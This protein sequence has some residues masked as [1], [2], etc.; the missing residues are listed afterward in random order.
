MKKTKKLTSMVGLSLSAT[1]VFA[2]CTDK[3]AQEQPT[4]TPVKQEKVTAAG[5]FPITKE[6]TTL[7]VFTLNDPVI[8]N[9]ETNELTKEYE[10]KTNIHID[11]S[12]VSS[13]D[14]EQKRNL[15]LAANS[16]LPDVFMNTKISNV[17][18]VQYGNQGVL[19][20]LNGLIDKYGFHIKKLLDANPLIKQMIT[21]PN[22]KIYALPSVEETYHTTLGQKLWINQDWL[23]KLGLKMPETTDELYTV[24]KAFKEKDPNGNGKADEIPLTGSINGYNTNVYHFILSAFVYDRGFDE[25]P[26]ILDNGKVSTS[27]D[28]AEWKEGLKYLNK[29]YKEG[30]LDKGAITQDNAQLKQ[31]GNN[32]NDVLIGA[33]TAGAMTGFMAAGTERMKSYTSVPPLK[34]PKGVQTTGYYPYQVDSGKFAISS[35]SKNPE[36]AIR[37]I[38]WFY[39]IDGTLRSNAGRQDIEWRYGKDG[40][41]GID[42]NKGTFF[43]ILKFGNTQNVHWNKNTPAYYPQAFRSANIAEATDQESIL[44]QETKKKYEPFKP[45]EVLPPFYLEE[46]VAEEYN[47][48]DFSIMEYVKE[49]TARFV[50][51]DLDADKDWDSYLKELDKIGLK[52]YVDLTQ[53]A[54]DKQY[55]K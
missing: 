42:G 30:L 22:G 5:S 29:L 17:Q 3:A 47:G 8:E 44:Y 54:Y 11:W 14:M 40:E 38:D 55:K 46:K 25:R 31:L 19:L 33:V 36:A 45:K 24:L 51:G 52:K 7:K 32:K 23:T 48:I 27:F 12:L 18:Q 4:Q 50:V 41:K 37:W 15:L 20:E 35:A 43:R 39:S 21:T 6:K 26:F 1:L 9:I 2:G 16:D 28:N 34:G 10:E 53:K 13:K 49:S